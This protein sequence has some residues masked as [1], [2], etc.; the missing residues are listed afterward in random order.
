[1]PDRLGFVVITYNQASHQPGLPLAADLYPE[2]EDAVNARDA[3]RAET[4]RNG[5]GEIH[6][7]AEVTELDADEIPAEI[8]QQRARWAAIAARA[9]GR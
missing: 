6:V 2:L 3:E 5:R 7:V 9:A 4:A 1:M 8:E